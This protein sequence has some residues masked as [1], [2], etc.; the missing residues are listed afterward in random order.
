MLY[1]TCAMQRLSSCGPILNA[2]KW[3]LGLWDEHI[4]QLYYP[5]LPKR[6]DYANCIFLKKSEVVSRTNVCGYS[7]SME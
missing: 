3:G 6:R 2:L 4:Y 1:G 5:L 7:K